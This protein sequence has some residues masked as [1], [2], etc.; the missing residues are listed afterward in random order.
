MNLERGSLAYLPSGESEGVV[1]SSCG[2]AI[3]PYKGVTARLVYINEHQE[4]CIEER[5]KSDVWLASSMGW[6]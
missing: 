6:N 5:M 4:N 3:E 1:C 2:V